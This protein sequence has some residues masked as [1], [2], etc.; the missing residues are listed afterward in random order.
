MIVA[1][2]LATNSAGAARLGGRRLLVLPL[3]AAILFI[4][5]VMT[6]SRAG[7]AWER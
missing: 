2:S 6:G 5:L 4:A 1:L 7:L 3:A